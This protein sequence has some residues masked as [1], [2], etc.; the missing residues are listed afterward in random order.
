MHREPSAVGVLEDTFRSVFFSSRPQTKADALAMHM[1]LKQLVEQLVQ[2]G[3]ELPSFNLEPNFQSIADDP[4]PV[5]TMK[6]AIQQAYKP[7]YDAL[8]AKMVQQGQ[9]EFHN[10]IELARR[11]ERAQLAK[12]KA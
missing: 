12:Q 7:V 10:T 2:H 9:K 4:C 3:C 1:Q 8:S 5:H 6:H 11:Y